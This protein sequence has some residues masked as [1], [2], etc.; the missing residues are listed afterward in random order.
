[1]YSGGLS[2]DIIYLA[3]WWWFIEWSEIYGPHQGDQC[4]IVALCVEF[5]WLLFGGMHYISANQ[6]GG[7][8]DEVVIEFP[9][10]I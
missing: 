7:M 2:L 4:I 10:K 8:K 1:M 9:K 5:G 6:Y 3:R